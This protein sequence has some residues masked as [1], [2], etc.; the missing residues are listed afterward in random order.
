MDKRIL[1]IVEGKVDEGSWSQFLK[2]YEQVEKSSL[3]SAVL[4]TYLTQDKTE[5]TLWRIV[6]MWESVEAMA[7]YRKSVATPIWIQIF[8]NAG[9]TPNLIIS[10]VK[11]S[12]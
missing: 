2:E 8:E 11:S 12:K 7:E 10:K 1:S 5:Q 6:T 3:P 9:A 4:S